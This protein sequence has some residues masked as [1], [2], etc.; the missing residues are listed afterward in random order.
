MKR[1]ASVS[2]ALAAVVTTTIS[3]GL[4]GSKGCDIA[5]IVRNRVIVR[6]MDTSSPELVAGRAVAVFT[7]ER[8]IRERS[9]WVLVLAGAIT[10]AFIAGAILSDGFGAVVLALF[11]AIAATA[12][13]TM[14]VVRSVVLSRRATGGR[15]S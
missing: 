3:S 9:T 6:T 5:W 4:S 15:R 12:T 13:L 14:F 8:F 2:L 7:L 1:A 11:G 10:A